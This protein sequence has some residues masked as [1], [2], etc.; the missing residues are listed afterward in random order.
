MKDTLQIGPQVDTQTPIAHRHWILVSVG[1][2]LLGLLGATQR[3]AADFRYHAKLGSNFHRL[4]P[5]YDILLWWPQYHSYYPRNF[6]RALAVA[7]VIVAIGL[8]CALFGRMILANTAR[9]NKYLHGSARWAKRQDIVAMGLI[10]LSSMK[11]KKRE[12]GPSVYVGSWID[13]QGG[14]HYLVDR[15]NM[16]VLLYAPTRSGK[17]ISVIIPSL[18]SWRESALILD[19][20]DELWALTAGW[21]QKHAYNKVLRWEPASLSNTVS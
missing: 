6:S 14:Q 3:F 10:T 4:Y 7:A 5:P 2:F 19:L 21:R 20:K 1:A 18:L 8:L 15:S 12:Q 9:F 11:D 13:P 16:H 17:G